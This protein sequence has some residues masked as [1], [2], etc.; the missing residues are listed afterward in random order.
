M[1]ALKTWFENLFFGGS[2]YKAVTVIGSGGKTSL[3][4]RLAASFAEQPD[5]KILVTPTTKMFVPAPGTK[6]CDHYFGS[7]VL[8]PD[9]VPGV[10]LA[11][12]FNEE[13]KKLEALPPAELE[14]NVSSYDLV[15]IEGDGSGGLPLK[16]W[17]DYEP[18][19][20]FFT[21]LTI[22]MLPLAPIGKPVSES[23]I[24]RLPLFIE[25][26]GAS[27][28]EPIKAEHI[29]RLITGRQVKPGAAPLPGLFAKARGKK[30]L[31]FNQA[32][33]DNTLTQARELAGLLP[34][35]FREGLHGII[36]GSVRDDWVA[37]L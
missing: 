3:I 12:I 27:P 30:L 15:L 22:G 26:T 5:R 18:V 29:L 19:V 1:S 2:R 8:P 28:G 10:S 4:W 33:N 35:R 21:D 9:P 16:A 34:Q 31:F 24:H 7:G 36:A 14:K 23:L 20:P 37:E 11:G 13:T 32:E 6:L 17:A 25:L